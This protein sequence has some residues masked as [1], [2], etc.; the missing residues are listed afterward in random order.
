[1]KPT[2]TRGAT[3]NFQSPENW[4]E[5]AFG[6]CN[7]LQVRM[8]VFEGNETKLIECFS[9]WKP[10]AEE[11]AHLNRGGVIEVGLCVLNQ[12]VMRVGVVD[13][14]SYPTSTDMAGGRALEESEPPVT[15]IN[16]EAHGNDHVVGPLADGGFINGV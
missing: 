5:G 6:K 1:M 12:P 14:V 9:T 2:I 16:E 13:P 10:S 4:D 11:L 8:D 15:T 7:D 3:N